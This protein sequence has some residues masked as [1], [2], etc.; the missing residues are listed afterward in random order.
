MDRETFLKPQPRK[1]LTEHIEG[2]GPVR[3][4]VLKES[5]KIQGYDFW[6]RQNGEVNQKRLKDA[7]L[8]IVA[9]CIVHDDKDELLLTD[10]DIPALREFDTPVVSQLVAL[11]M[12]CS[13][14]SEDDF[15]DRLKKKSA[16]SET[17][18]D[19]SST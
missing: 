3:A 1:F 11:A 13:G 8:K 14:M 12:K 6:L 9:L 15:E 7:R 4:R 18:S 10:S 5:E 16:S 19:D 2:F 17:P